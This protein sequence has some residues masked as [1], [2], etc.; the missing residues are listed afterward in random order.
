MLPFSQT[1]CQVTHH[2]DGGA[3]ILIR[4]RQINPQNTLNLFFYL[5]SDKLASLKRTL[6]L[7]SAWRCQCSFSMTLVVLELSYIFKA[8]RTN[9]N[10]MAIQH[11]ILKFTDI[12]S[13]AMRCECALSIHFA[14]FKMA[15][16]FVSIWE[17]VSTK[18]VV[19]YARLWTFRQLAI[20]C[21]L[22]FNTAS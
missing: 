8:V 14:I 22:V 16:I 5:F 7:F 1:Q 17:G 11:I 21:S 2:A 12:F 20:T 9:K 10:P 13:T 19:P 18:T 3:Q 15:D 6:H 4:L